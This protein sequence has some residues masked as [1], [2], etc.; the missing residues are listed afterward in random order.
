LTD[1][2]GEERLVLKRGETD[3]YLEERLILKERSLLFLGPVSPL[4]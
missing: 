1:F 2:K 3:S 4:L